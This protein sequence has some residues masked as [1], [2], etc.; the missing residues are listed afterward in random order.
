MNY[1]NYKDNYKVGKRTKFFK[2]YHPPKLTENNILDR[3]KDLSQK[4]DDD[5]S[6]P[7][8]SKQNVSSTE[9]IKLLNYVHDLIVKLRNNFDGLSALNQD[10]KPIDEDQITIVVGDDE[11]IIDGDLATKVIHHAVKAYVVEALTDAVE[12]DQEIS[13]NKND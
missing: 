5:Y 7:Y 4:I 8:I 1:E 3:I 10:T 2:D 9:I 6:S 13:E 11:V 12:I